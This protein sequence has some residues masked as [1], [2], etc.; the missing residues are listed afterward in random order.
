MRRRQ[1]GVDQVTLSLSGGHKPHPLACRCE[2]AQLLQQHLLYE[3]AP[4]LRMLIIASTEDTH[5]C[6]HEEIQQMSPNTVN[7]KG[8]ISACSHMKSDVHTHHR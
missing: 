3:A 7:E 5:T 8:R 6:T 2:T 4:Q 1:G